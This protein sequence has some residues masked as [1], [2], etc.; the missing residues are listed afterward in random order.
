[1]NNGFGNEYLILITTFQKHYFYLFQEAPTKW[2]GPGLPKTR[3]V[4]IILRG[5][6]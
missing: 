6:L 3:V 4:F 5:L 1:V 2:W